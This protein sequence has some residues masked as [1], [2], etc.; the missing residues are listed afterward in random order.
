MTTIALS[1]GSLYTYGI[2]RVFDLATQAGF[3]A[4][5]VMVDHRWDSR[6]PA[7]LK[8][9][10]EATGLPIAAV[11]SP[12]VPIVPGWPADQLGRLKK[13]VALARALD[14]GVVVTHL[15]LRTQALKAEF[16]G[17][18]RQPLLLPL[19]RPHL[20]DYRPFLLN[21]LADFEAAEGVKVGVENMPATRIFGRRVSLYYLNELEILAGLPHLTFD[22]TH[23]GTWGLDLL[24]AYERLKER[25]VHVHLSNYDGAQHRLPEG[26]H[27]PLWEFLGRLQ[28]DGYPGAVALEVGPEVL[29][30]ENETRVREH[31]RRA[32]AYCREHAT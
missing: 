17:R 6:Q 8:R 16:Y 15:P 7:Y 29:E 18:A 24:G 21:G 28:R 13:T 2:A 26:G 25:I 19:F 9:L 23:I 27:L 22:T 32:V 20:G 30:A 31:L 3:D 10:S 11:H 14:V 5:E 1:T 12:F 4:I